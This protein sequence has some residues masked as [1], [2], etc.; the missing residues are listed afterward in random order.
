[1]IKDLQERDDW[2]MSTKLFYGK[3]LYRI[4]LGSF[5]RR[6]DLLGKLG[7]HDEEFRQRWD[8]DPVSWRY[9]RW[10]YDEH[11]GRYKTPAT[12]PK[13]NVSYYTSSEIIV[14]HLLNEYESYI[15]ETSGPV[16]N[17]H[18]S[19]LE[20]LDAHTIFRK[21]YYYNKYPYRLE[22]W[23]T[24]R[25]DCSDD[26]LMEAYEYIIENFNNTEHSRITMKSF[27][28]NQSNHQFP[29]HWFGGPRA[30]SRY[31]VLPTVYTTDESALMMFKLM[32]TGKFNIKLTRVVT[33]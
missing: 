20:N 16:S 8:W 33:L 9:N 22:S 28:I 2:T 21:Q 19:T 18:L 29:S 3:F 27:L 10:N 1:M 12:D 5:P 23:R 17:E 24:W 11:V 7:M 30:I 6:V 14:N 25:D 13:F 4:R 15:T 31:S 32:F 26:T